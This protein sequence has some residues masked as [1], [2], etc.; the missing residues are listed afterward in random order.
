LPY[1][2]RAARIVLEDM[3]GMELR[4]PAGAEVKQSTQPNGRKFLEM[5]SITISPGQRL[6]FGVSGLPQHSVWQKRIR[7]GVGLLA[8]LLIGWVFYAV[9]FVRG[10]AE[11]V[12]P[13]LR[14]LE[15][16]REKL[17]AELVS[18]ETERRHK[19]QPGDPY[20]KKRE[21]LNSRLADVYRKIDD[22]KSS[23]R[24]SN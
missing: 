18:L 5:P 3:P 15:S 9:F 10:R 1:G 13:E 4:T 22:H 7:I 16:A 23:L 11:E 19:R 6:V 20:Q 8:V 21:R 17:M 24:N 12:D 14:A 2:L